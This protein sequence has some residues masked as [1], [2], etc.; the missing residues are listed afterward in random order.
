MCCVVKETKVTSLQKEPIL[1]CKHKNVEKCH[2]TYVTQ[3]EPA[4]EEVC[5]EN[6]EKV[7]QITFK[8]VVSRETVQK[9]LT[10]M[11]KVCG[12]Q[13]PQ[14][15]P[16]YGRSNSIDVRGNGKNGGGSEEQCRTYYESSCTTRYVEKAPGKFVG[17][18]TCEKQPIKLCGTG[19]HMEEGEPECH[20]KQIDVLVDVPEEICDLNPQKTCRLVTRLVPTLKPK[21]ECTIIPQEI[22]NLKFTAPKSIDKPLK[23]KWC[24]DPNAGVERDETYAESESQAAPISTGYGGPQPTSPSYQPP[25]PPP[26]PVYTQ[27]ESAPAST[28]AQP[29]PNSYS[30]PQPAA[31]APSSY[32]EPAPSSY[33]EPAPSSYSEPAPSSYSEPAPSS[34]SEPAPSS[35]SEPAP[36][37]YSEPAPSSYSEPA[38]SSYSSEPSSSYSSGPSPAAPPPT[39]YGSGPAP[40][41][42]PVYYKPMDDHPPQ[43]PAYSKPQQP[44]YNRRYYRSRRRT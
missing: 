42:G 28:Y 10:P 5:D 35:Y 33:S 15:Q 19:C 12:D 13:Q 9:C 6:F 20:D 30:Q 8:K 29:A 24:I 41:P 4:Q 26:P 11:R 16:Q 25:P 36:S 40:T 3:F 34:Y 39:S 21:P 23:T 22:C 38:P 7:C 27:A 43:Q 2:Y 37:S 18:T 17:D 14:Y 44:A 32:S 1:E 31:P